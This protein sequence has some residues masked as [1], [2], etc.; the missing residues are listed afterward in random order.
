MDSFGFRRAANEAFHESLE[1]D[2]KVNG[3]DGRNEA[4]RDEE[5]GNIQQIDLVEGH[6]LGSQLQMFGA[7]VSDDVF[8]PVSSRVLPADQLI[9]HYVRKAAGVSLETERTLINQEIH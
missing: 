6:V 1:Q 3:C 8:D 2:E 4:R 9:A 7:V 5:E